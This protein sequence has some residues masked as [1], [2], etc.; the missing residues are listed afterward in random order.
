M[1]QALLL[2]SF[3][4]SGLLCRSHQVPA[5]L[6]CCGWCLSQPALSLGNRGLF[7]VLR[8]APALD[9]S[10]PRLI[11]TQFEHLRAVH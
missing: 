5:L 7:P 9:D 10:N 8:T 6:V 2:F 1:L 3:L 11:Y 4:P